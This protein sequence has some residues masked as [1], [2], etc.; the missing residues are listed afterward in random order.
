M[1]KTLKVHISGEC[2]VY[3]NDKWGY[4]V[5]SAKLS[6]NVDGQWVYDYIQIKFPRSQE[7]KNFTEIRIN[8]G[9]FSFYNK[10]DGTTEKCIIITSYDILNETVGNIDIPTNEESADSEDLDLPW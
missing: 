6:N 8:D 9:F 5:Y 10:K 7:L 1:P 4:P 3:R 2:T